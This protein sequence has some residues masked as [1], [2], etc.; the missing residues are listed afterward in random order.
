MAPGPYI[1]VV[2]G[3]VVAC[4]VT[5]AAQDPATTSTR[6]R[7]S[8][9]IDKLFALAYRSDVDGPPGD[10]L[11]PFS[12]KLEI[13]L[14]VEAIDDL[15]TDSC[16]TEQAARDC[17]DTSPTN[18]EDIKH[19]LSLLRTQAYHGDS[20]E[21]LVATLRQFGNLTGLDLADVPPPIQK[22]RTERVSIASVV[23]VTHAQLEKRHASYE[24]R[25]RGALLDAG[26]SIDFNMDL[27]R[28]P[29]QPSE[30]VR[31]QVRSGPPMFSEQELYTF[32]AVDSSRPAEETLPLHETEEK[33]GAYRLA[34][35][36][37][38]PR[39]SS[40]LHYAWELAESGVLFS[41]DPD[42]EEQR[43]YFLAA[44]GARD[45]AGFQLSL[46]EVTGDVE[47][48]PPTRC[49]PFIIRV[50]TGLWIAVLD[51]FTRAG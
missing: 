11:T 29:R 2:S 32:Q 15:V 20:A 13:V 14:H 5:L 44:S 26:E 35:A 17:Y 38:V 18:H 51:T 45:S 49:T 28:L 40:I 30:G 46:C 3:T 22:R 27:I 42:D 47:N 37:D 4:V 16:S 12:P 36:E 25:I 8:G 43:C 34:P 33:R 10:G 41:C 31:F 24:Q 48:D 1:S 50:G 6:E 19:F 9:Y 39:S 7:L 21:Q 23:G